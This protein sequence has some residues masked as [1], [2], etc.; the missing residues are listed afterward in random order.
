MSLLELSLIQEEVQ[1]QTQSLRQLQLVRCLV[2]H[3]RTD[4]GPI[5]CRLPVIPDVP[6]R[7]AKK[8]GYEF[9][10]CGDHAKLHN[11]SVIAQVAALALGVPVIPKE[12]EGVVYIWR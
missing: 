11:E 5:A 12:L 2:V 7:K 1:E 6:T 9:C 10:H 3:Y 8:A 4:T